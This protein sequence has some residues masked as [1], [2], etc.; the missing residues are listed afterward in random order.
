VQAKNA[1]Q[2]YLLAL[3]LADLF[4]YTKRTRLK[5][6]RHRCGR[7][8]ARRLAALQARA[9]LDRVRNLPLP[10]RHGAANFPYAIYVYPVYA[11]IASIWA[12]AASGLRAGPTLLTGAHRRSAAGN[13]RGLHRAAHRRDPR[14][15]PRSA[16]LQ[17]LRYYMG[18]GKRLLSVSV[19]IYRKTGSKFSTAMAPG[20]EQD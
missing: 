1:E 6:L 8:A 4:Q 5:L 14:R 20:G 18:R 3:K 16:G 11:A 9:G 7:R 17:V 15:E 10:D 2:R 12:S 13:R 19:N